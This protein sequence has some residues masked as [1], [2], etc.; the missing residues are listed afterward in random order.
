MWALR[1]KPGS[2]GGAIISWHLRPLS[3]PGFGFVCWLGFSLRWLFL[4]TLLSNLGL[5]Y[6][7]P[8]RVLFITFQYNWAIFKFLE[9]D[10]NTNASP[11]QKSGVMFANNNN[12]DEAHACLVYVPQ[13]LNC[14]LSFLL[15]CGLSHTSPEDATENQE[16]SLTCSKNMKKSK[17]AAF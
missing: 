15:T 9:T 16:A 2:S 4:L 11:S 3:G 7:Q 5:P 14:F 6:L 1:T 12:N 17:M 10:H 13:L 8:G